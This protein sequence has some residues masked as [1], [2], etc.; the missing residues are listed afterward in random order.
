MSKE[1]PRSGKQFPWQKREKGKKTLVVSGCN[2]S[3]N[4]CSKVLAKVA[5]REGSDGTW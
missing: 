4:L 5:H 3:R 2:I 1:V